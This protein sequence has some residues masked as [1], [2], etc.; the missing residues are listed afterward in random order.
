M[1]IFQI[2]ATII[3]VC[4]LVYAIIKKL[5][6]PTTLLCL[7]LIILAITS[8]ISGTSVMRENTIG[9]NFLDLFEYIAN[10]F[11]TQV[12]KSGL[13]I[14]S[15]MGFVYYMNHLKASNLLALLVAKPLKKLKS[16]YIAVLITILLGA[17]LKLFISSHAGLTT[18]LM[19]TIYPILIQIGVKKKTAVSTVVLCGAYDFGP[20]CPVTNYVVKLDEIASKTNIID[21]F[22]H[23]QLTITL[24]V[25]FTIAIVFTLISIREDKRDN[26]I[27]EEIQTQDP[28]ELGIP[29][30]YAI[31]PIIPLMLVFIF[32]KLVVGSIVISVTAANILAFVLVFILDVICKKDKKKA[33]NETEKF[34]EGM[35]KSFGNVIVLII[36]ASVFTAGLNS[37]GGITN[38]L[39]LLSQSSLGGIGAIIVSTFITF[40][41]GVI[42]GSGVAATYTIV[43][44]MPAVAEVTGISVLKFVAPIILAGGMGRAIS[45]I[46]SAV[47]IASKMSDVDIMDVVKRNLIPVL[48]GFMVL[49]VSCLIIL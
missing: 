30:F 6:A 2:I 18:L 36:G 17:T 39:S 23:W 32:S 44:L 40:F 16:P 35:G 3:V 14:M 20:A 37:I 19:A 8:L 26:S 48:A 29:M 13:L 5:N 43:P 12:T 33:F 27:S 31:F 11:S 1:F 42:T 34:F 15:V 9:N 10:Q 47:I 21:F 7:G 4:I 22:I 25:I 24:M 41:T 46:S 45:P 49:I 28:K 38:I